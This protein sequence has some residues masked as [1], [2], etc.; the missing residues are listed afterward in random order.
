[1]TPVHEGE[2]LAGKY[3]VERVLGVGGMGV[4]VSALHLQL[5]ERVAIKFLLPEALDNAE[6]VQ[7]F[8]REARAAVKIKSLHVARVIDVGTLETGAP[9]MVME[10]LHGQDLSQRLRDSGALSVVDAVD[11]VLQACEALAEAHALGIVHRDL[12]PANLF[13]TKS[14]DGSPCVKVLDFG[15]SKITQPSSSG[16]DFGMT[17]TQAIMGSP[18]YMSPEQMASSRDVD[19][20][21]DIWA[22]GTIL[23]ELITGRVPFQ[24]DTMP[25]LC[26]MILQGAPLPPRTYRPDIPEGL[27]QVILK[28]LEKERRNRPANVADLATALVPYG[29]IHAARSAERS[30]RV[31]SAAGISS[32]EIPIPTIPPAA[33]ALTHSAWGQTQNRRSRS[34]LWIGLG[35]AGAAG[36]GIGA[37]MFVLRGG[38]G[39]TPG[40]AASELAPAPHA[41]P[42]P[43]ASTTAEPVP[44][45]AA[46][47]TAI[48]APSVP[49]AA[50]SASSAKPGAVSRPNKGRPHAAPPP[51]TTEPKPVAAP[52]PAFDPL[53]DR[54]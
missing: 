36:A 20:R 51:A 26:T 30:M 47:A 53:I 38:D 41:L 37:L 21:S 19:G 5:D 22:V 31:L 44:T 11:F 16:Q 43:P 39:A 27:Q 13:L 28:C 14:A 9:Y 32:Q 7:R 3:R 17:K 8:S 2:I 34:L 1:M 49:S 35:L 25:Q 46:V 48:E 42:A 29:S 12:K 54:R 15:I 50:A 6:A 10:F 23:Y 40:P 24:G 18:L 45:V 52:K 4:V 33:D